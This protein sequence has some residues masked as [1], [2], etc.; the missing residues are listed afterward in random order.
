MTRDFYADAYEI[1][2]RLAKARE[3]VWADTI[4]SAIEDGATGT[5]IL[6][7]LRFH[8]SRLLKSATPPDS[9]TRS[10]ARSLVVD[11][12]EALDMGLPM[13]LIHDS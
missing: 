7:A 1:A 13:G 8:L 6:M 3:L 12:S 11:L 9:D 2:E 4:T 5:E 10:L